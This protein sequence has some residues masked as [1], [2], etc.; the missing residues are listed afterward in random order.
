MGARQTFTV[1]Q[2]VRVHRTKDA[3]WALARV[4]NPEAQIS[5]Y[6]P[7]GSRIVGA[8]P[9]VRIEYAD[10]AL[11]RWVDPETGACIPNRRDRILSAADYDRTVGAELQKRENERLLQLAQFQR[12]LAAGRQKLAA[13]LL[14]CTSIA[15]AERLLSRFVPA[16][17]LVLIG[18]GTEPLN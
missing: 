5:R 11:M 13:A 12:D 17:K 3:E 8:S 2:T 4:V 9:G 15:D 14:D 1:G 18:T 7:Y 10:P 16:R 6:S